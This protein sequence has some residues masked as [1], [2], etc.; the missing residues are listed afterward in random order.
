MSER[1]K[2]GDINMLLKKILSVITAISIAAGL[3]SCNALTSKNEPSA[4]ET[5]ASETA[6][7]ESTAKATLGTEETAGNTTG[8][9]STNAA[10][11]KETTA[12]TTATNTEGTKE[13]TK[14][15]TAET[16]T[17]STTATESTTESTTENT[18]TTETTAEKPEAHIA[19]RYAT[20][21]EGLSLM[22]A[23]DAY[24]AG[25]TQNDIDFKMQMTGASME[26]YL[27]FASKQVL[28]FS[29]K[30]KAYLDARIAH[31]EETLNSNG[32]VL[33]PLEEIVFIKTTM[34]EEAGA[35]GYTHGTQIYL[36]EDVLSMFIDNAQIPF[37]QKYAEEILWHE[38]FHCLTRCNPDFRKA[39]YSLINFTVT[40]TDFQ[41]PPSV[42][43]YHISNPDVEH[44]DAY[45]TFIINGQEIDCFTDLVT[46]KHFAEAR[47]SFFSCNTTALIPVDGTDTYYTPEQ[48][49]NFDDVFGTNTG[50]VIDPEECMADNFALAMN[51][52]MNGADNTGYPNPEIVE[53]IIDYMKG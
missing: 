14:E 18:T 33:P 11:V 51:Y 3:C 52:G 34:L 12:E 42:L 1:I 40:G 48:A 53:G 13:T 9:E 29:E 47:S 21:E 19:H 31:M 30:E 7:T 35:G 45:A 27:E 23:N 32:Y 6:V 44:H 16:T 20:A 28:V 46:T 50:Y 43:E 49:E 8:T 24:Y 17:T 15:T 22:L 25:F 2:N 38:L 37:Y 26:D 36:G 4:T 41:L 5:T 39:M 10:T